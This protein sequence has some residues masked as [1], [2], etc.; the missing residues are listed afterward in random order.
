MRKTGQVMISMLPVKYEQKELLLYMIFQGAKEA[1]N[2]LASA[3]NQKVL[4]S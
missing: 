3:Q 1:I 2:F 4:K